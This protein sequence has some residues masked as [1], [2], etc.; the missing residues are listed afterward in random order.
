MPHMSVQQAAGFVGVSDDTLR[1][2]IDQGMLTAKRD[3][4]G[5]RLLVDAYELALFT[6]ERAASLPSLLGVA[7]SA[8]NRFTGLVTDIKMDEVMAQVEMQCGPFRVVSLISSEAVR[9]L[10]L[11]R[12]S[13][14]TAVV[15][16]TNVVVETPTSR[17]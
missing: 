8:R 12:G 15:K 10:G 9:E 13:V 17:S 3:E 4:S 1:R 5:R 14:V 6:R 11:E 7:S 16:A 2:W